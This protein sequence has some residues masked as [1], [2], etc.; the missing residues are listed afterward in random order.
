M[1]RVTIL[2]CAMVIVAWA[3]GAAW[4]NDKQVITL[5]N[6]SN[7]PYNYGDPVLWNDPH[8]TT[9]G[10]LWIDTG[11][12]AVLDDR[13][14]NI[15]L[16]CRAPDGQ[17]G[18]AWATVAKL[19]LSDGSAEGDVSWGGSDTLGMFC[20]WMGTQYD[21][22]NTDLDTGPYNHYWMRLHFW[23]GTEN[24]YAEAVAANEYVADSGEFYQSVSIGRMAFP[25]ELKDMPATILHQVPEPSTLLLALGG[26]F[27]LWVY[28][29]RK[30][31]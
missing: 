6:Y 26:L 20:D 2:L 24:T 15:Q 14:V 10:A 30:R 8:T 17:G 28:G 12:G 13:D 4:A 23:T 7:C 27:G 5:T 3:A 21:I 25:A 1:R 11:S 29:W 19:L 9:G 18:F 31:K 16:D 22:P